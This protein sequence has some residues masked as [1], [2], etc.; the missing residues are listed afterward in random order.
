M[1][2]FEMAVSAVLLLFN[3]QAIVYCCTQH[4][5]FIPDD[6]VSMP[7]IVPLRLQVFDEQKPG[8]LPLL[9]RPAV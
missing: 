6:A 4:I 2:A 3:G 7:C 8:F 1:L 5:F 9:A